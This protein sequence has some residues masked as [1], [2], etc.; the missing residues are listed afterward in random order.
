MHI[1]IAIRENHTIWGGDLKIAYALSKGLQALGCTVQVS[2][3]VLTLLDADFIFLTNS[4]RDLRA[5]SELLQLYQKPY[6]VLCFHEDTIQYATACFGFAQYV[7]KCVEG[8]S[9]NGI[10]FT[11]ERLLRT[12]HIVHYFGFLPMRS[13]YYNYSALEQA[14]CCVVHSQLEEKTLLRDCPQ[15][16]TVSIPFFLE[17]ASDRPLEEISSL[18]PVSKG[19]Y[20]LQV[21]RFETRKNQLGSIL[22]TRDMDIP[23]VLIA[24]KTHQMWYEKLCLKVALEYRKGATYVISETL[25]SGQ[26]GGLRVIKM[27]KAERLSEGMIQSAFVNAA[28]YLHPTFCEV[29]GLIFLEAARAGIPIV[30]SEWSTIREVDLQERIAYPLPYDILAIEKEVKGMLGSQKRDQKTDSLLT[31]TSIDYAKDILSVVQRYSLR[32]CC[33]RNRTS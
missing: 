33:Y 2:S 16:K 4:T 28:L 6:G 10:P 32:N 7:E 9:E 30:A 26:S 8:Y 19:E 13:A 27:P 31:R 21:G 18:I 11:L 22:A 5:A 14:A 15:A 24:T 25:E 20:I 23:L 12:P 3:T 17:E 29:P 1:G